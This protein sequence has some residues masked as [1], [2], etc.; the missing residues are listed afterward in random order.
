[1]F[2]E[3]HKINELLHPE[4]L[5][6]E[7]KRVGI[8]VI[9]FLLGTISIPFIHLLM[10]EFLRI[11][12]HQEI[13]LGKVVFWWMVFF[14]FEILIFLRISHAIKKNR[15]IPKLIL[16]PN[17]FFEFGLTAIVI[18]QLIRYDYSL[19]ILEYDGLVF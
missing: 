6:I 17:I 7:R 14:I 19:L 4:F 8:I 13:M 11:T 3:N 12:I 16:L 15:S 1:M 9:L 2:L 18:Y 10:P 5:K